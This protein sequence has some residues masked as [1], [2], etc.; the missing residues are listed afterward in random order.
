MVCL[1]PLAVSACGGDALG[2]ATT[3]VEVTPTNFATIPPV[4]STLPGVTTLP[5]GA[6]GQ[7]TLYTVKAGDTPIGVASLYGISL[8]T[9]LAYNGWVVSSQFPFPGQTLRIPPEAVLN[10]SGGTGGGTTGTT[11]P[12]GTA[13]PTK[14]G[15]RPA[16]T[17][18]I[19]AGDYVNSIL[20]K[21]CVSW[22][23]TRAMNGW[24]PL[25]SDV[26][27]LPGKVINI[28]ASGN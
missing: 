22:E 11:T 2:V 10:G 1:V 4:S 7:E 20:S 5:P 25:K 12:S 13:K 26:L 16:G 6:I 28:P 21:F 15:T 23:A 27:L 24:P 8:T 3:V 19:K 9:L 17:Y 18:T 14:C